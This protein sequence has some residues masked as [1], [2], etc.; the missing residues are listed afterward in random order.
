MSTLPPPPTRFN[1]QVLFCSQVRPVWNLMT[2]IM[3]NTTTPHEF[4]F[5]CAILNIE[6]L[7]KNHPLIL[8]TNYTRLLIE[9]AHLSGI[10]IHPNTFLYK[11]LN[12]ANIFGTTDRHKMWEEISLSCKHLLSPFNPQLLKN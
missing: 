3:R 4:S 12:L 7:P 1:T 10:N 5:K 8:L 11:I 9:K 2:E 6:G